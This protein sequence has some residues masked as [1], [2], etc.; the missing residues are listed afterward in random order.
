M[1]YEP[2]QVIYSTGKRHFPGLL[3]SLRSIRKSATP[4]CLGNVKVTV[5]LSIDDY[6]VLARRLDDELW[7]NIDLK[8]LDMRQIGSYRIHGSKMQFGLLDSPQNYVR[9]WLSSLLPNASLVLYLDADTIV[10][11]SVC[12]IF[13]QYGRK[14][15]YFGVAARQ[16]RWDCTVYRIPR[17][18]AQ[19]WGRRPITFISGV[20]L[21]DLNFWRR[22]HI[23]ERAFDLLFQNQRRPLWSIGSNPP[24]C[25]LFA[26]SFYPIDR[27]WHVFG[28]GNDRNISTEMLKNAYILHWNGKHKPWEQ[29][30]LWKSLWYQ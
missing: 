15:A 23:Q 4:F 5:F 21:A 25:I 30:G 29:D 10:R 27:R 16:R 26:N 6:S 2:F 7:D 13:H 9:F 19:Q 1:T 11:K 18:Y 22:Y 17:A 28:L 8:T 24:L 20:F 3:Q 12:D 14:T